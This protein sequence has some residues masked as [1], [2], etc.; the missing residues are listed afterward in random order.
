[1][2]DD[3]DSVLSDIES[4]ATEDA[5]QQEVNK[6]MAKIPDPESTAEPPKD[7]G[8]GKEK[9]ED[10]EE[11]EEVLF[12]VP[13]HQRPLS[14]ED[15]EGIRRLNFHQISHL[16]EKLRPEIAAESRPG[17]RDELLTE[18]REELQANFDA[19]LAAEKAKWKAEVEAAQGE[20][21][22]EMKKMER[23]LRAS[24]QKGVEKG[25]RDAIANH[26]TRWNNMDEQLANDK[27][28]LQ[29]R[30]ENLE[31]EKTR[32]EGLSDRTNAQTAAKVASQAK[33]IAA[34][35]EENEKLIREGSAYVA[36]L[37]GLLSGKEEEV[38]RG[39]E[40][41]E[42]SREEVE[43]SREE[44]ESAAEKFAQQA[45][46]HQG[47]LAAERQ[48][49][50]EA[51]NALVQEH[52]RQRAVDVDELSDGVSKLH[53]DDRDQSAAGP[54]RTPPSQQSNRRH[55]K[56]LARLRANNKTLRQSLG[57]CQANCAARLQN[58]Q[59]DL[60]EEHG[61]ELEGQAARMSAEAAEREG[62]LREAI[63]GL[64][65][66]MEASRAALEKRERAC[67]EAQGT[68][69]ALR[70]RAKVAL[71]ERRG[72]EAALAQKT[73]E[74][75][76]LLEL[77]ERRRTELGGLGRR[78]AECELAIEKEAEEVRRLAAVVDAA[79]QKGEREM[80]APLGVPE[81]AKEGLFRPQFPR[82]GGGLFWLLVVLMLA[83]LVVS[84]SA[85]S[86]ASWERQMELEMKRR[87][88]VRVAATSRLRGQDPWLDLS[89]GMYGVG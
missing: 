79:A 7:K 64:E 36:E 68:V 24:F 27:K 44:V 4:I 67:Q 30:E 84:I 5:F 40:E 51:I 89:R 21:Q 34:L 9:E 10:E 75:R 20:A 18:L 82:W 61:R 73:D 33:D 19:E 16:A 55:Q 14:N 8:K 15:A 88:L 41:V 60:E 65:R 29:A 70:E 42:G 56:E 6:E 71:A 17:H 74:C 47:Q 86:A 49:H 59:A 1:M 48:A 83:V 77:S 39:R 66:D 37:R 50:E 13:A 52:R 45:N 28:K 46:H 35:A 57:D 81:K 69:R 31:K 80:D 54:S 72:L 32:L 26:A 38:K 23:E 12:D 87:A 63:A 62:Q 11:D 25:A 53:L 78:L 76:D 58:L 3:N 43:R 85:V 22:K 2:E